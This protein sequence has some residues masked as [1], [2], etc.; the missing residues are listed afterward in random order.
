MRR[1]ARLFA[2][3][4][5]LRGK[6]TGA[7]TAA[8]LASRFGVSV[9]TIY[10][11]LDGL[12]DAELPLLADAG[13]GGGYT[14]DR[15]YSLPPVN[16]S[17]REAALLVTAGEMLIEQ[18]LLPFTDTL[19]AAL[20]KVR[21]ALPRAR[22]RELGEL[23]RSVS[24]VGVPARAVPAT[25]RRAIEEAWFEQRPVRVTYDGDR[26]TRT[27]VVKVEAVVLDRQETRLNCVDAETGE[28]RQLVLHRL[29][30][31]RLA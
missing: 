8:E 12:R 24:Y 30:S 17:A 3:A 4:E 29:T 28:R 9:R 10:R 7:V 27:R 18:R 20:D 2:L 16:F 23:A 13:R 22:Q 5:H 15:G 11:D 21:A 19:G 26:G 14:L 31:A 6:R 1:T 25:V